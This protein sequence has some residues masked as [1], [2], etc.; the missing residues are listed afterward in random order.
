MCGSWCCTLC[1]AWLRPLAS[2]FDGRTWHKAVV[3]IAGATLAHGPRTVA[4]ALR[5]VGEGG[6]PN[7]S[8]YHR[9]LSRRH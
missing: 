5:A 7:F 6:A 2:A 1:L 8:A 3:L 9:V 4:S